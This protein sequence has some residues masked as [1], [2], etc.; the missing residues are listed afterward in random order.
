MRR[1]LAYARAHWRELAGVLVAWALAF[2]AGRASCRSPPAAVVQ[3]QASSSSSKAVDQVADVHQVA[4][5]ETARRV[6]RRRTETR[7]PDGSSV[8]TTDTAIDTRVDDHHQVQ[9]AA[10]AEVREQEHHQVER[11]L[12]LEPARELPTWR[13][14]ALAG[15][16]LGELQPVYGG[17]VSR[18]LAGPIWVGAWGLSSG[19]AGV[20]VAVEW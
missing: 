4:R 7:R 2:A 5:V 20:A 14:T 6:R 12:R 15:L 11:E 1:W 9:L 13:V 16:R 19:T 10:V 18:R 8:I 3:E 17:Q